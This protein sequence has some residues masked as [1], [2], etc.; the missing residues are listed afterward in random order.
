MWEHE[1]TQGVRM[2]HDLYYQAVESPFGR[3]GGSMITIVITVVTVIA[4]TVTITVRVK[5]R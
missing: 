3:K 4:F 1:D 5:R 2:H